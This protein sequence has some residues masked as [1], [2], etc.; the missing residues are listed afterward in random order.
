MGFEGIVPHQLKHP[1][2]LHRVCKHL[3]LN[4]EGKVSD[5][6]CYNN[7]W[8]D[9]A[10]HPS[11]GS[12]G[13]P[14]AR[15]GAVIAASAMLGPILPPSWRVRLNLAQKMGLFPLLPFWGGPL[16]EGGGEHTRGGGGM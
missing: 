4:L 5:S 8:I 1:F 10:E 14:R 15:A 2:S 16:R 11:R 7:G 12:Y 6:V 13:P 9:S 3:P